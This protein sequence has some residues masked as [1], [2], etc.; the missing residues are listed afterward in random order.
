MCRNANLPAG[1]R[2]IGGQFG[3]R[4]FAK[5]LMNVGKGHQ[6]EVVPAFSGIKSAVGKDRRGA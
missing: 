1:D 5:R 6:D 4:R 3:G 2:V